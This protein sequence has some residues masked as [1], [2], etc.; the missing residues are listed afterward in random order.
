MLKDHQPKLP[1][2]VIEDSIPFSM[3]EE[4]FKENP[5]NVTEVIDAIDEY[6]VDGVFFDNLY[7]VNKMLCLKNY[8]FI[9]L[10]WRHFYK[11]H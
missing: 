3:W 6:H 1:F 2:F 4:I 7:S 5:Q 11:N 10:F 8:C 9:F